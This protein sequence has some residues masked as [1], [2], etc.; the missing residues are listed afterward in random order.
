MDKVFF[1]EKYNR[2]EL[3]KRL[4]IAGIGLALPR[5]SYSM[6]TGG[7]KLTLNGKAFNLQRC[8]VSA[9]PIN[10]VWPGY[11][12]PLSQ[13]EMAEFASWDMD[14]PTLVNINAAKASIKKV[15]IR[16]L[17]AGIKPI[18]TRNSIK[19][20][21]PRPMNIVVEIDGYHHAIH[22]FANPLETPSARKKSD[23]SYYFGPGTHDIGAKILESNDQVYI[24]AHAVVY[25]SF[26]A[27]GAQDISITGRGILDA[28]KLP[29]GEGSGAIKFD[30]CANCEVNGIILRDPNSWCLSMF[31]CRNMY[32]NLVKLI[33]LWRYNSDG[34]DVCNSERVR[35]S[36]CFI[37]SYDDALVVKGKIG[38]YQ[39]LAVKDV[40]FE[41][42]MIWCDWGKAFEIGAETVAPVIENITFRNCDIIRTSYAAISIV[43]SD[44]AAIRN[45]SYEDIRVEMDDVNYRP[46]LQTKVDEHYT[47]LDRGRF[48]PKLF[49]VR[50]VKSTYAQQQD[51]GTLD[52]IRFNSIAVVR[53]PNDDMPVSGFEGASNS[54][55]IRG[56]SIKKLTLNNKLI[57]NVTDAAIT[58]NQFVGPIQ[59]TP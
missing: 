30:G 46:M 53:K 39:N 47:D 12:R 7:S 33:G 8:R 59:F 10:Q 44:S 43:H 1:P 31:G 52:D 13:T 19:F 45:V 15:I 21:I 22:L 56:V 51:F 9:F 35:V 24:A 17:S 36:N 54:F 14:K 23:Y 42:C 37:R 4:I 48:V 27:K 6:G 16:P 58:T 40:L 41:N 57:T 29:R 20:T 28:S 26:Y 34:I 25:G 55:Q 3:L 18:V 2:K 50:I 38:A 5:L 11:Q 49:D 32:V